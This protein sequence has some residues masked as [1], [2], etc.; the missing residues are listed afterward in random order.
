VRGLPLVALLALLT[1]VV[2]V[3]LVAWFAQLAAR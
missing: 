3:L 2:I 1:W